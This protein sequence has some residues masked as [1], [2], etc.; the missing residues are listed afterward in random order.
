MEKQFLLYLLYTA[1]VDIRA[2]S[3]E[4]NDKTS[5][6]LCDILHNVPLH[7]SSDEDVNETYER[8]I[9]NVKSIGIENWLETRKEEFYAMY[10]EYKDRRFIK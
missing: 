2:R 5:F 3:Y 1:L 7:I 10:P 8:V 6:W 9:D 4:N